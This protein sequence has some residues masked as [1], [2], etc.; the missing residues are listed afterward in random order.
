MLKKKLT[1]IL[2][3][4]IFLSIIQSTF[5]QSKN[6]FTVVYN[7][8]SFET[9]L[10]SDWGF[11][12]WIEIGKKVILFDT[13]T[14]SKILQQNLKKLKFNPEV[15]SAIVISHEHYDHTGGLE[16]MLEKVQPGTHV[17]LPNNFDEKLLTKFE[18]LIFE[19]NEG[20][21]KIADNIWVSNLFQN[22]ENRI[23][24]QALIIEKNNEIIVIT[25]CAHPG[26][27]EMCT[28]I[29]EYFP[30]KKIELVTG[31]FHLRGMSVN[32]VKEI[33]DQ[34]KLLAIE[35][36]APSHCTGQQS[37]DVFKEE[38]KDN[39]VTLNLGDSYKF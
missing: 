21:A 16:T 9:D 33:S 28:K 14:K 29:K 12:A 34:L 38:W 13:G 17:Y 32:K 36:V 15:V 18:N 6:S 8:L 22:M 37:I 27:V 35:K 23:L 24:E 10:Q 3:F 4:L 5:S 1:G 25:G 31:G 20:F 11:A 7:N 19:F 30:R 39:Y 26:I 2:L